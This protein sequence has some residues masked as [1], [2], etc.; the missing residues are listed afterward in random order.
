MF[1]F[2]DFSLSNCWPLSGECLLDGFSVL[3]SLDHALTF[4]GFF[5]FLKVNLVNLIGLHGVSQVVLHLCSFLRFFLISW[6]FTLFVFDEIS[7]HFD[8]C[9]ISLSNHQILTFIIF[10]CLLASLVSVSTIGSS[11]ED[12]EE[13]KCHPG[14]PHLYVL[15]SKAYEHPDISKDG[16]DSCN[17]E[18][19]HIID[20]LDS[21]WHSLI[22]LWVIVIFFTNTIY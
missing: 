5:K 3:N 7:I 13:R 14:F 12:K 10:F 22:S 20:L 6:F 17:A 9:K 16:C 18:H 4:N 11:N 8:G 15:I 1:S 2:E 21:F 19:T